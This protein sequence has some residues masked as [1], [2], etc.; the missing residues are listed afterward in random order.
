MP[1]TWRARSLRSLTAPI[2]WLLRWPAWACSPV[3]ASARSC[4][5][6]RPIWRHTSL[7]R[8]W[9]PCCTRSTFGCSPSSW[10]MSSTT[11]RIVSSSSTHPSRH[12][13]PACATSSPPCN[14]SS[15]KVRATPRR[16]ATAFSTTTSFWPPSRAATTTRRS[17]RTPAPRCVTRAAPPVTRRGS[18]TAT[19]ARTCTHCWSPPLPTSRSASATACW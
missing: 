19:A 16:W 15:S 6:T 9:A 2:S 7:F 14:T 1:R 4:G 3:I 12:C 18:C 13:W 8:A 11:P 10:R 5:T 17:A